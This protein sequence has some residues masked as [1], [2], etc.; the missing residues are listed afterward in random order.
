[1]KGIRLVTADEQLR[2]LVLKW[3]QGNLVISGC[4]TFDALGSRTLFITTPEPWRSIVAVARL[5]SGVLR[6]LMVP[7]NA[8][9]LW[10]LPTPPPEGRLTMNNWVLVRRRFLIH[11]PGL[12][13]FLDL[14]DDEMRPSPS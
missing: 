6:P 8:I 12:S 4:S 10:S 5:T 3:A 2:M 9:A 14:L 13:G 1:M 7:K 11:N